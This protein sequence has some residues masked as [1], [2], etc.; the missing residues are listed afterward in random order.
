MTVWNM[1]CNVE[2]VFQFLKVCWKQVVEE[3][4]KQLPTTKLF[5]E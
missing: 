1:S 4:L 3:V 2:G 5:F